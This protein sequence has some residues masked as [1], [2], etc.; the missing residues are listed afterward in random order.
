M[1]RA[2]SILLLSSAL[3]YGSAV[4]SASFVIGDGDVAQC[5]K[6]HLAEKRRITP[7]LGF[8]PSEIEKIV[9][10][11]MRRLSFQGK[12]DIALCDTYIR[13]A[14]A[15]HIQAEPGIPDGDYIAINKVWLRE[16]IGKDQIQVIA[17]LGHELGHITNRHFESRKDLT[18]LQK[19]T[20]ADQSAGCAVA[21]LSGNSAALEDFMFRMRA[22]SGGGD[23]PSR[24]TSL[25]AAKRGFDDCIGRAPKPSPLKAAVRVVPV[26]DTVSIQPTKY[27]H[28]RYIFSELNGVGVQVESEDVQWALLDGTPLSNVERFNRILGGSFPIADKGQH[29][30][31]NNIYL[32][33]AIASAARLKSQSTVQLRHHF[34]LRDEKGNTLQVPATLRIHFD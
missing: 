18:Y 30:Y 10:E 14:Y 20:E 21:S 3:L 27:H 16:V 2:L 32:P 24:S 19:E 6:S 22:E 34:N 8:T 23:Y 5:I 1:Q 11:I 25:A 15:T 33:P 4:F 29:T 7:A 28:V 13:A 26:P 9:A 31:D 17:L 12:I